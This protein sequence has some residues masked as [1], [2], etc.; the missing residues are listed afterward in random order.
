MPEDALGL[1]RRRKRVALSTRCSDTLICSRERLHN[2]TTM[3]VLSNTTNQN[4]TRAKSV[5]IPEIYNRRFKSGKEDLDEM[6][7]GSGFMPNLTFTLAAAPGTGKTSMLLQV[8][9]LLENT[10]K[11]TAYISGEENVEQ[12]AFT[13]ARLGVQLV[14]LANMTDIDE[15]CDA[16]VKNDFDFVVLDSLPAITSKKRMNRRQLEEYVTTKLIKTAKEHEVVIGTIL[17]FTKSGTYKG[18]TLLPHSVDCNIIMTRNKEDY[19]LR[20]VDVT[21]NRF[22][23]AG[24]SIFEMTPRGFT[25]DAVE[26]TE[27]SAGGKKTSKSDAIL[28]ILDNP[29]TVAQIAQESGASGAYLTTLLRQLVNEGKAEKNGRG[30][31]AT[32]VKK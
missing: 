14:P 24:S 27:D 32:Y 16:I 26:Q 21:K 5:Q 10:G 9:E 6:F 20:D 2:T 8:L 31:E 3:Q 12:L 11:K 30:A 29:K 17:H 7:G 25:F 4:F 13:S 1:Q 23:S 19:N 18:S 22:G 28:S 15:I